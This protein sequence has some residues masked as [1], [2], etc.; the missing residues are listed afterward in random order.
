MSRACCAAGSQEKKKKLIKTP[1][2]FHYKSSM[3]LCTT[4]QERSRETTAP[5]TQ[6]L[7]RL[8]SV[9]VVC[10]N[11]DPRLRR[12]KTWKT[13]MGKSWGDPNEL[14]QSSRAQSGES[15]AV[16]GANRLEQP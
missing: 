12:G 9:H 11:D 4:V 15:G 7:V 16:Q 14:L 8:V 3:V 2:N 10:S 6:A 1:L 13:D 5:E